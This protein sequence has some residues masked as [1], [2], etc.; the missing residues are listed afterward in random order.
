MA[1]RT[2]L[3]GA[4]KYGPIQFRAFSQMKARGRAELVAFAA[5]T[6]GTVK[7]RQ[8]EWGMPGYTDWE[9]M[10]EDQKPDAVVVATP[11]HLHR[12]MTVH[13]LRSGMHVLVEKPMDVTVNGAMEMKRAA[14]ESGKLLQVDMHKR[15]DAYHLKLERMVQEGRLGDIQYGY[16]WIEE[17]IVMPSDWFAGWA[18]K[19]SPAWLVGTHMIDLFQWIVKQEGKTVYATGQK[20][21]LTG[22]GI[23]TYDSI[24]MM[25]EFSEGTILTVHSS[26]II[27]NNFE[28]SIN[29]GLR[30]VGTEGFMEIDSQDRGAGS[31]L[32]DEGMA[33]YNQG[34]LA[35]GFGAGGTPT[36][37]GYSVES[38]ESFIENLHYLAGGGTIEEMK[39]QYPSG[40]EGLGVVAIVEAAH[41]SLEEGRIVEIREVLGS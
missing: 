40:E 23:D 22:M 2:V 35:E 17:K 18:E 37:T 41:R 29:Q 33:S 39:G 21:K 27:P 8:K 16:T 34:F 12:E 28:G 10:L 32:S 36:Y 9:K 1:I 30:I 24:Q 25:I 7:K 20:G 26:W 4:G 31:C 3:I 6:D 13:A 38:I 14:G 5:R 11:D 19:S 15:F